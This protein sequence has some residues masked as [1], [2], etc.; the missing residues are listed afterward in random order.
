[1]R[2]LLLLV[3]LICATVDASAQNCERAD[4]QRYGPGNLCDT[5]K[6]P[7]CILQMESGKYFCPGPLGAQPIDGNPPIGISPP[8]PQPNPIALVPMDWVNFPAGGVQ[9]ARWCLTKDSNKPIIQKSMNNGTCA[10]LLSQFPWAAPITEHQMGQ[11]AVA[12]ACG[13]D[14]A[15]LVGVP[16][17]P[18][19]ALIPLTLCQCHNVQSQQNL[20]SQRP[21]VL[22]ALRQWGGC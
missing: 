7:H 3:L 18:D 17:P 14:V 8:P 4:S 19:A 6:A 16:L 20:I 11:A 13:A 22:A 15:S 5:K 21:A 9:D 2:Y 12:L 10:Q 1:M